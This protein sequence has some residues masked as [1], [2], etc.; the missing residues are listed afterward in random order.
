MF[1]EE[2][3]KN[4]ILAIVI[5]VAI[6]LGWQFMFESPRLERERLARQQAN[7]QQATIPQATAQAPGA[8]GMPAAQIP[9]T[10]SA[11][12]PADRAAAIGQSPRVTIS[13]GAINGSIRLIGGQIDDLRLA[14]Y[15][16][17]VDPN[18]PQITLLS[19]QN[20]PDPYF[21]EFGWVA[22]GTAGPLPDGQTAWT[23]DRDTLTPATPVTLSWDNGAG[24]VFQRRISV[25]PDFM[26]EIV[27]SVTNN[28]AQPVQLQPYGRVQRVGTPKT[29]GFFIL[30]EGPIG[31]FNGVLNEPSYDDVK[32]KKEIKNAST[33]GW[34]GITDK[35]WLVALVPD[36]RTEKQAR[37]VHTT[38]QG[39]DAY[40]A[41]YIT[42]VVT[43]TPGG[44]KVETTNRLFAGA[45]E[46]RLLDAYEERFQI[47]RFDRAVD[48][49]WFY[50]L[51]KPIFYVLDF[52]Y[53]LLGNF[54]L[55]ILLLTL[56]VKALFFP[57]ANKSYR[58]MSKMKLLQPEMEKLKQQFGND[59]Q[60]MSQAMMELYRK[61]GANPLA[62]CLPVLIQ[63]PVFFALYKVLFVTI[64]MRHAPF[65]GWI[66]DL[67][68]H[69]PTSV[70]NL[71]GLLPW[72]TPE[73]YLLGGTLGAWPLIMGVTMF[74]QQKMNPAPPDPIQ[75]KIFMFMPILF[76]FMLAA[77]PAGL[78]IYWAWN[79]I[80]SVAQQWVIMRQTTLEQKKT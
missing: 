79:N 55:A 67:S 17:T 63:I 15:R 6:V 12:P 27:D 58:A 54:G 64:E 76:T 31:V 59:Q 42:N 35:Y 29:L 38:V 14:R 50:W 66:R 33:G 80:L 78:V 32:K 19:P 47:A 26:F 10:T 37:F 1:K 3:Q 21:A 44:G 22:I 34:L 75:A 65:Y 30:H 74:L 48:F 62:G 56:V 49:G 20:A 41:D 24:L 72:G 57:L 16:D 71:F 11:V 70:F 25:D 2:N 36:Q 45:K 8:P 53:R 23:A 4:L 18:S 68:A 40:Q 39:R 13:S 61:S 69:D 73:V 7:E 77:F 9:G 5:S 51:T 28:G 60:K 43:A 46:V 52:F